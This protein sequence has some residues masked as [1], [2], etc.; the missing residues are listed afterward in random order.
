MNLERHILLNRHVCYANLMI[1][2][3]IQMNQL[4]YSIIT[5]SFVIDTLNIEQT[6]TDSAVLL[7]KKS[8]SN[9]FSEMINIPVTEAEII[10]TITSLKSK[11]STGYDGISDKISKLSG[12]HLSK[13]LACTYNKSLMSDKFPDHLKY[14][15]VNPLF[16][17]GNKTELNIHRPMSLLTL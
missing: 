7:L 3:L 11:S 5:F 14:T 12:Q 17:K 13:P 2:I 1:E 15:V 8:L 9:G 10:H 6:N 4:R 16:K